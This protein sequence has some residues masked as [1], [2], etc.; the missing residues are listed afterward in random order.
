LSFCG[1]AI[2]NPENLLEIPD[3]TKDDR[4]AGLFF[5]LIFFFRNFFV[6]AFCLGNPWVLNDP[7]IRFYA[8]QP[9][10]THDGFALVRKKN[11]L[12]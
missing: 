4:F 5:D 6:F 3:A 2:N 1:H 8:G 9:L 7:K 12:F 11:F 10:V